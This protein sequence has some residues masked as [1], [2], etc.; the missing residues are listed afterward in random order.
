MAQV[1][2]AILLP[3]VGDPSR[4]ETGNWKTCDRACS[5]QQWERAIIANGETCELADDLN[6][7]VYNHMGA[8]FYR[9]KHPADNYL[10]YRAVYVSE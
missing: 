6:G 8:T 1:F 7:T 4:W 3:C 5:L 9:I 2:E 10:C